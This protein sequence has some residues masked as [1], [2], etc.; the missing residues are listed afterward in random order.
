MLEIEVTN[1]PPKYLDSQ[2]PDNQKMKMNSLLEYTFPI[3]TDLELD[4]LTFIHNDLPQFCLFKGTTYS[5]FPI[6][7]FG[8]F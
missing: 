1:S 3:L 4:E 5:F 8:K 6:E 2:G 7:D